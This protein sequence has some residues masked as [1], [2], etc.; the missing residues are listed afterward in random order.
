[1]VLQRLLQ[2]RTFWIVWGVKLPFY[3]SRPLQEKN[4]LY[5]VMISQLIS[6]GTLP[7]VPW[8]LVT[9][10]IVY[11]LTDQNR[12]CS[13]VIL[14]RHSHSTFCLAS[15]EEKSTF[16]RRP[17]DKSYCSLETTEAMVERPG[18]ESML[19]GLIGARGCVTIADGCF[20]RRNEASLLL[21][22]FGSSAIY[23]SA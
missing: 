19:G 4:N 16:F 10:A 14:L 1:M 23:G 20:C 2:P 7:R 15:V 21:L 12:L 17:R 22:R 3:T 5:L 11:H 9:S 6:G 8:P 18:Y 13:L